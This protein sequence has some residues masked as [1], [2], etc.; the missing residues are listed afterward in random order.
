MI[1]LVD[2]DPGSKHMDQ[3][4]NE[5]DSRWI[6]GVLHVTY[7]TI[8]DCWKSEDGSGRFWL[9]ENTSNV[10]VDKQKLRSRQCVATL[11]LALAN[12][13]FHFVCMNG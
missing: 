5:F 6:Q 1:V 11:P 12:F 9:L 8:G 13:D 3:K 4:T 7:D 2:L 10:D